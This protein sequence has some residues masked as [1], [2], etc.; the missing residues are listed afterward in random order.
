MVNSDNKADKEDYDPRRRKFLKNSGI[1]AGG[2]VGGGLL[3]GLF[4]DTFEGEEKNDDGNIDYNDSRQFFKRK[5]DFDV[6]SA[7]TERIFP[8]EE[9][10]PGAIKLGVP[11]YID[12]QLAGAWGVN[13]NEYMSGPFF[14]GEPNQ[15]YQTRMKR[16]ELFMAGIQAIKEIS[17]KKYEENFNDLEE[18]KQDEILKLLENDEIDIPGAKSSLFFEELIG[19]TLEGVYSDPAY[20]GN[21]NMAGWKMKEYPGVQMN[22][23]EEELINDDF[24]KIKPK[25]LKEYQN[26]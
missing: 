20:G 12:R 15:G 14:E 7:A 3:V 22:Y 5:E 13:A 26:S 2:V 25:P 17:D 4:G 23:S 16:N 19:A 10:G 9:T 21:K 11:Y 1:A 6:I 18:E 8:E 24:K